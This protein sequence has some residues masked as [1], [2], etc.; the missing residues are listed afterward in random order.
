MKIHV[1][2]F[3]TLLPHYT[4]ILS[5]TPGTHVLLTDSFIF[6]K[7]Y[8]LYGFSQ[9]LL[10]KRKENREICNI[11]ILKKKKNRD[12]NTNPNSLPNRV[13]ISVLMEV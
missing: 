9:L 2:H 1:I 5:D 11:R 6:K 10:Q 4:L 8:G 7:M 13:L 3:S 12:E